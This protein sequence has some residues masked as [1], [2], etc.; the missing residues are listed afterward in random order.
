[1]GLG[2]LLVWRQSYYVACLAIPVSLHSSMLYR[3]GWPKICSNL[4]KCWDSRHSAPYPEIQPTSESWLWALP[5]TLLKWLDP[6]WVSI[7]TYKAKLASEL[8]VR[9]STWIPDS[10]QTLVLSGLSKRP[11][12]FKTRK[13]SCPTTESVDPISNH[14]GPPRF[15]MKKKTKK[16]WLSAAAPALWGSRHWGTMLRVP[17][18]I[19]ISEHCIIKGELRTMQNRPPILSPLPHLVSIPEAGIEGL[20]Y[21]ELE[22]HPLPSQVRVRVTAQVK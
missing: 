14:T 13:K 5:K 19:H 9:W 22:T 21:G 10:F 17:S 1:M 8:M 4:P 2:C 3:S 16:T 6:L 20:G 7:L 18:N 11:R 12:T 15:S